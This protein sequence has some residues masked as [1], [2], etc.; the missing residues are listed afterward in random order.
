MMLRFLHWHANDLSR[1]I[2]QRLG[3]CLRTTN[4]IT[5]R[6]HRAFVS[7]VNQVFSLPFSIG[8]QSLSA[9]ANK[10]QL[11]FIC[12]SLVFDLIQLDLIKSGPAWIRGRRER[13]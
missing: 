1:V 12:L 9:A 8:L 2:S 7:A 10:T 6:L 3:H 4:R 5:F 13:C 11:R